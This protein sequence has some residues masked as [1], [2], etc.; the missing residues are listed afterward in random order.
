[1]IHLTFIILLISSMLTYMPNAFAQPA[2]QTIS[3]KVIAENVDS[4]VFNPYVDIVLNVSNPSTAIS[5]RMQRSFRTSAHPQN[6]EGVTAACCNNAYCDIGENVDVCAMD[7][8]GYSGCGE[9]TGDGKVDMWDFQMI[10]SV[11]FR[12]GAY[13][14][15]INTPKQIWRGDV[16]GDGV[17]ANIFD[18]IA[19]TNF[20]F[21]GNEGALNCLIPSN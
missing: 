21:R 19:M 15:F 8:G 5:Q 10:L 6:P 9:V 18:V 20:L 2:N 12:N 7:C 1:M 3:T 13:P 14:S 16:N 17:A 11:A 4:I